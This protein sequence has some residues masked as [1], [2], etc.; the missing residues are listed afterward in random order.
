M[1]SRHYHPYHLVDVSPWPILAAL[2]TLF[3]TIGGALTMHF[4]EGGKHLLLGGLI[5]VILIM[6]LWLRDVIREGIFQKKHTQAVDRGLNIGFALFITSE[7]MFFFAFFWTFFHS[8]LS[9]TVQIGC[10]WPP[11]GIIPLNALE[12]PLLNT[13]ILLTSGATITIAHYAILANIP[14]LVLIGFAGTIVLA[15]LFTF[16]QYYEYVN[17]AF[18]ISDSVYGSIF[19]M[20]T[21]FHGFHVIIGTIFITV[22][23][24]RYIRGHFDKNNHQGFEFGAWYWHSVDVVRIF[25]F[26]C[27]YFWGNL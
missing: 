18:D 7:V 2:G 27:V 24:V 10:Y 5:S 26:C 22:N 17:A 3:L 12:V 4:Y 1:T 9:P 23:L 15:V 21:G 19:Y 16:F 6:S 20:S 14:K 11:M 25:L 8:S 13:I